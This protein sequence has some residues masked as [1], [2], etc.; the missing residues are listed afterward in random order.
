MKFMDSARSASRGRKL[1]DRAWRLG[2][3]VAFAAAVFWF[4]HSNSPLAPPAQATVFMGLGGG[5]A[6]VPSVW[7]LQVDPG[8]VQA[9]R[10][11]GNTIYYTVEQ[12]W[13]SVDAVLDYYEE[14]YAGPK[15]EF[16]GDSPSYPPPVEGV[17]WEA[18]R[19]AAS[20]DATA[21]AVRYGN[22]TWGI[23]GKLV[24]PDPADDDFAEQMNQ[25]LSDFGETGHITDLGE[26]KFVYALRPPGAGATTV[27]TAWPSRDF[28]VRALGT[29][30]THDVPGEDPPGI[31][32]MQGDVR[33]LSF[34]QPRSEMHVYSAEYQSTDSAP[35]VIDFY[36]GAL[37]QAQWV[38]NEGIGD[39]AAGHGR[40]PTAL[41]TRGRQQVHVSAREDID[42]RTTVA[43]VVL[44]APPGTVD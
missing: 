30:G 17:D 43:T 23:Y 25:R 1:L 10:L 38:E 40:A 24:L 39:H 3:I 14:L 2:A 28:N 27:M 9:A 8:K 26:P 5:F 4:G 21:G 36:K 33:L 18:A 7:E 32:R 41:F 35:A 34:V 44:T 11:N 31:P 6:G 15:F 13:R 22:E 29:D 42:S 19:K 20:E 37:E 12:D 16:G